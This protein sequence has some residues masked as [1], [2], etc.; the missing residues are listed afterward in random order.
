MTT[1]TLFLARNFQL[2]NCRQIG[3][4]LYIIPLMLFVA[5]IDFHIFT[6]KLLMQIKEKPGFLTTPTGSFERTLGLAK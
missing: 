5:N 3:H 2:I 4:Y 1:V 6:E